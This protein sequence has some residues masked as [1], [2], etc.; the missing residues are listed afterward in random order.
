MLLKLF[1]LHSTFSILKFSV[2]G[3]GL[4]QDTISLGFQRSGAVVADQI[5]LSEMG[6]NF[7]SPSLKST[8]DGVLWRG[9]VHF[10]DEGF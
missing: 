3:L 1:C 4:D 5:L 6:S 2:V 9:K 10:P 7:H 8:E